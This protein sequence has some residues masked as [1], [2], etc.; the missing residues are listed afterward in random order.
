MFGYLH[1]AG[2]YVYVEKQVDQEEGTI[3]YLM[4]IDR[5]TLKKVKEIKVN[6][7]EDESVFFYSDDKNLYFSSGNTDKILYQMDL[8]KDKISKLK[9]K[10][11]NP[12]QILP[13]KINCL[14]HTVI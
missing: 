11:I 10:E 3:N 12:Q 7:S 14:L 8:K 6:H 13:Y 1:C 5:K 4:K 9:L 2:N